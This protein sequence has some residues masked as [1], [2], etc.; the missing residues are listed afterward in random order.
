MVQQ[1]VNALLCF[2]EIP[3]WCSLENVAVF[4]CEQGLQPLFLS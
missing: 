1:T 4:S 3:R 2:D